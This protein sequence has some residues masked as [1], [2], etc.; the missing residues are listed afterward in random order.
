MEL[1]LLAYGLSKGSVTALENMKA[2]VCS[3]SGDTDFFCI[4]SGVLQG[5]ACQSTCAI[6]VYNLSRLCT[7]NMNISNKRVS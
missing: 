6:F 4:V 2:M 7:L 5:D 3:H 1:M